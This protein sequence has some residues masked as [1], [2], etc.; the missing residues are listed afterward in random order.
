MIDKII[1][2]ILTS[3]LV[4]LAGLAISLILVGCSVRICN[5][6]T[7]EDKHDIV[8]GNSTTIDVS[9]IPRSI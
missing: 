7:A 5:C 9:I 8:D 6:D 1:P 2:F 4:V 3:I